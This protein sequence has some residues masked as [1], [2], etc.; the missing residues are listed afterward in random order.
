LITQPAAAFGDT[1][2]TDTVTLLD[3]EYIRGHD[4]LT[5]DDNLR[6]QRVKHFIPVYWSLVNRLIAEAPLLRPAGE[7]AAAPPPVFCLPKW[8]TAFVVRTGEVYDTY[9]S[10]IGDDGASAGAAWPTREPVSRNDL[11]EHGKWFHPAHRHVE[12][13]GLYCIVRAC[14]YVAV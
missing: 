4:P 13:T 1:I 9:R 2:Y 7:A 10:A 3:E 12:Q 5:P 8:L 14:V 11:W 6:M